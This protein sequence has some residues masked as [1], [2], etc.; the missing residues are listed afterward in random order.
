M[1]GSADPSA[2][3]PQLLEHHRGGRLDLVGLIAGT[4]DLD[5]IGAALDRLAA[6]T[7]A[8]DVVLPN[9]PLAASTRAGSRA[10]GSQRALG[11][12]HE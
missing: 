12:H 2:D 4:V 9:G 5:D 8:R 3:I 11:D 10:S 1:Y 6:G 7:G